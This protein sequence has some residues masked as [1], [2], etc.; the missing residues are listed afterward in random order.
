MKD[1]N[2]SFALFSPRDSR[3]PRMRIPIAKCP[4]DFL[5]NAEKYKDILYLAGIK[6]WKSV[7]FV[8]G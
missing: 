1:K 7:H 4:E 2:K 3:I 8:L 6:S 5:V